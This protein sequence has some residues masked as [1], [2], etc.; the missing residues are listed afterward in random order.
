MLLEIGKSL[1]LLLSILSLD[2]LLASAFF[3]PGARWDDRLINSQVT[4]T[5]AADKFCEKTGRE[6]VVDTF[7]SEEC[8]NADG[9]ATRVVFACR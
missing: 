6:A 2:A 1:S 3:V 8:P 7:E 4:A 5:R 9:A